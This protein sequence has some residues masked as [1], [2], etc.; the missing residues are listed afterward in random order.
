MRFIPA[1]GLLC[2]VDSS[3]TSVP[4]SPA[5]NHLLEMFLKSAGVVLAREQILDNFWQE[6]GATPSSNSLNAYVSAI[7][8][9]L[10]SLGIEQEAI[11]T[12]YKV[13]FVFN[14]AIRIQKLALQPPNPG[15]NRRPLPLPHPLRD[16]ARAPTGCLAVLSCCYSACF[17]FRCF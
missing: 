7:R 9:G 13:G 16:A 3:E 2:L 1:Q 17:F 14:P 8:R 11:T 15:A 10:S 12:V 6:T 4:L 5:C